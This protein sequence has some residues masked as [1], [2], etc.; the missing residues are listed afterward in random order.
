MGVKELSLIIVTFLLTATVTLPAN[1]DQIQNGLPVNGC[2][3]QTPQGLIPDRNCDGVNDLHN[4]CNYTPN[5]NQS[6]SKN[7]AGDACDL[8]ITQILLDPGTEV[9]QGSFVTVKVQLINNKAYEIKDVQTRIRNNDLQLDTSTL[10]DAMQP[11]E[12]RN[13]D[14]VLKAP[15]CATPGPYELT[16]TT[17]HAENGKVYTQT[18][19]QQINVI[20]RAGA[21]TDDPTTLD[22]TLL[23]TITQ[24]EAFPGDRVIYPLTLTNMN[25][26]TKTYHLRLQ[27]IGPIGTYRIDPANNITIAAGKQQSLYLYVETEK[28]APLGRNDLNLVLEADGA[29]QQ[30]T[31]TLRV[32]QPVGAP[33]QQILATALQLGLIVIVLGLIVA[34]G[35][36]AYKRI[37]GGEEPKQKKEEKKGVEETKEDEEFQSY[38]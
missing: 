24:Q 21:C 18:I 31:L 9:K 22:N 12:Q 33:L 23:E 37:N 11:G 27:D 35:I 13:I 10:I 19:Y 38:Y 6:D 30:T 16:F 32:I 29:S 8:L 26:E 5:T 14:F 17:D 3:I 2:A 1:A 4:N 20:Q 28:F 25:N 15:G 7:G 34:A 36:I